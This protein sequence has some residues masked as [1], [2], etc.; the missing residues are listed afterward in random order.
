MR[1]AS[2]HGRCPR[3][4]T[5]A[6]S[7]RPTLLFCNPARLSLCVSVLTLCATH[8]NCVE[9]LCRGQ[10]E[11]GVGQARFKTG[12]DKVQFFGMKLLLAGGM[13][14]AE[15]EEE[16]MQMLQRQKGCDER[17]G[18]SFGST[19]SSRHIE[20]R[21]SQIEMRLSDLSNSVAGIA[22][23]LHL[24]VSRHPGE[25]GDAAAGPAATVS[26][27]PPSGGSSRGRNPETVLDSCIRLD[28]SLPSPLPQ[29]NTQASGSGRED[30]GAPQR[31][32]FRNSLENVFHVSG[33]TSEVSR[34]PSEEGS[35]APA[36]PE[37]ARE[38]SSSA[39]HDGLAL[40]AIA[41]HAGGGAWPSRVDLEQGG[42]RRS[43]ESSGG[44]V[45]SRARDAGKDGVPQGLR[46]IPC[47]RPACG[48]P[49][50][51]SN[52]SKAASTAPAGASASASG[53]GLPHAGGDPD[54]TVRDAACPISTG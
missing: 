44:P 27:S 7:P 43:S 25:P 36:L 42:S 45:W 3:C 52:G 11:G 29:R 12:D 6:R 28:R 10:I 24:F 20:H 23:S 1:S 4:G 33:C 19:E 51:G 54:G 22:H 49:A 18:S 21:M 38:N 2:Q 9:R 40:G 46:L 26:P 31:V 48:A 13:V 53:A 41:C 5:G 8:E 39:A 15:K 35:P 34:A 37:R 14:G 47:T 32:Q 30:G 50:A 16:R 17:D